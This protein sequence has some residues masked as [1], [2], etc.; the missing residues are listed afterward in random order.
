MDLKFIEENYSRMSAEK[1]VSVCQEVKSLRLELIPL[2]SNVYL[3]SSN[4]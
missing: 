4:L 2:P 1:L 3:L